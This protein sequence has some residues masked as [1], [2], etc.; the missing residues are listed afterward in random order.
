[1]SRMD[2]TEPEKRFVGLLI[3]VPLHVDLISERSGIPS[4]K[5][6]AS[7]W[8]FEIKGIVSQQAG[9]VVALA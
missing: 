3:E 9:K 7:S 8:G 4:R 2:L 1:M 5:S 6:W